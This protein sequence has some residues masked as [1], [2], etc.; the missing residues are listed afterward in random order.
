M[1]LEP[2][3]ERDLIA[4]LCY[5]V[6]ER[7]KRAPICSLFRMIEVQMCESKMVVY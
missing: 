4:T 3:L 1:Q 6:R 7:C 2:L 5:F